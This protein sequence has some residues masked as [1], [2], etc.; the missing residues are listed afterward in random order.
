MARIEIPPVLNW[1]PSPP[2]WLVV[3]SPLAGQ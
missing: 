1:M 2:G 3:T